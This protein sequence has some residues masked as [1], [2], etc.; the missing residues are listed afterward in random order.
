MHIDFIDDECMT[1]TLQEHKDS[2]WMYFVAKPRCEKK[3]F[4]ALQQQAIPSYLPLIPKTTEYSHRVY[5]RKVAMLPGYVFASTR[6]QGFDISR[7]NSSLLKVN[8]LSELSAAE[9]LSD[10]KI[11]RKYEL[12]ANDFKVEISPEIKEKTPVMITR[13]YFKGEQGIVL[14]RKNNKVVIVNV[15]SIAL[16]MRVEVPLDWVA[17]I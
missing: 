3:L 5:T 4:E 11:V 1:N 17:T 15:A 12:L 8:F 10:L 7:L 13:G 9:L 2:L 16:A 6:S 14:K